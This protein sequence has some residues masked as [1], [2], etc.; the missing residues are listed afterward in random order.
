LKEFC[1]FYKGNKKL[2]KENEKE[3]KKRIKGPGETI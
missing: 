2:E 1:K 3:L